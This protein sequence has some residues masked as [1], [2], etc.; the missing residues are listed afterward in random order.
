[1]INIKTAEKTIYNVGIYCRL[2]RDDGNSSDE[3]TS[4]NHQKD[5]L[6]RYVQKEG[7][8]LTRIYADDGFSGTNFKRPDFKSMI[9]DIKNGIINLVLTKDVSRLGR[10]YAETGYYTDTFFPD[11]NVRFIAVNDAIDSVTENDITPFKHVLNEMY[12]KDI[13]RK[14]RSAKKT[15]A[16]NG[17]FANSR[18]P[19]GYMKSP[20][21]K[22]L[23]VIDETVADNVRRI[24][25]M[26][27]S[28]KS[29]RLIA[30][31]FNREGIL[32]PNAYYYVS[33]KKPN[34]KNQ[35][36]KWGSATVL[37][38]IRNPVYRGVIVNGK[39]K[40]MSFKNKKVIANPSDTWIVIEN[41]HE[42]IVSKGIWDEAQKI[43]SKNHKGIR[44][45]SSGEVSLFSGVAKCADCNTKMTFNRKVYKSYTKE[46]YRC[47]RYTNQGTN[48]CKPH[49]ILHDMLYNSVIADIREYA[50]LAYN[51]EQ[52]LIA[53]LAKDNIMNNAQKSQRYEKLIMEKEYRLTE[54]D[55]LIQSLFE[56]KVSGTVPENIFRRMAKK[57]DDEQLAL[58]DEL[59]RLKIELVDLRQDESDIASWVD[60]I[61]RCLS[62]ETLTREIVVEL[63]D[64]IEISDVYE[65]DGEL[66]QDVKIAYRFEN[67]FDKSSGKSQK[68]KNKRVS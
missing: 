18:A 64:C 12:A 54:I 52:K 32:A 14:V 61:K 67:L 37:S 50:K 25:N 34:P 8:N 4:I 29:G 45:S 65:A 41:A 57:Y 66:Q 17:K 40:V 59:E 42:A 7:W 56:E 63:I 27:L 53:R 36:A 20:Q 58:A 44:R 46:Y 43:V 3:S 26:F 31:M 48:A 10:N 38:I 15:L 16:E 30:D 1:M 22:H 19:Y 49:T 23:L 2:S 39:R 33:I 62:I 28:G 5:M 24:Y 6:I 13:S 35:S 9:E 55:S 68:Q 47:G 60:K 11:Y 21:D 51:D